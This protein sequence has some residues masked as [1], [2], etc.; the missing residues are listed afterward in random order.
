MSELTT[1]KPINPSQLGTEL[2]RVALRC[3]GPDEDGNTKVRTDAVTQAQLQ[4]AVDAHVAD[5]TWTDPNP[6]SPTPEQQR[7]DAIQLLRARALQVAQDPTTAQFTAVQ[8]Q[9]ILAHY[10]LR[11]TR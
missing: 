10:V 4:T 5:P 2:G 11:A 1:D 6:P 8:M 7:D 9:R 3:V